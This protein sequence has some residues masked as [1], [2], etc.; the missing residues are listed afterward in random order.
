[1]RQSVKKKKAAQ[2]MSSAQEAQNELFNPNSQ[3]VANTRLWIK[4]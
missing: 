3:G 4:H 2:N 1:M